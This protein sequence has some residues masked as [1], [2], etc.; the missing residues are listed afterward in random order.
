MTSTEIDTKPVELGG[1]IKLIGF[2]ELDPGSMIIAKKMIGTYVRKY[3]EFCKNIQ[4]VSISLKSVHKIEDS[5]R[6]EISVKLINNG[7]V[8]SADNLEDRKPLNL[9]IV[10]DSVLAK[11]H[12]EVAKMK[13]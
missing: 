6:Y 10:L 3:S 1:N 13:A 8:Y 2:R 9:F 4:E 11:V 12:N 7:Q 5:E